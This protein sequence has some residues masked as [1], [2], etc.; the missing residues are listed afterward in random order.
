MIAIAIGV[1]P[2]VMLA[3]GLVTVGVGIGMLAERAAARRRPQR[4]ARHALDSVPLPWGA[5]AG[6][7]PHHPTRPWPY[8]R[9]RYGDVTVTKEL[10]DVT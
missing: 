3:L 10:D 8:A 1:V 4:P 9:I 5:P 7:D 6:A 2:F